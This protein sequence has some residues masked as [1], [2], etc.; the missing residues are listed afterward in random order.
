MSKKFYTK[1]YD[2]VAPPEL[3]AKKTIFIRK[4]DKHIGAIDGQEIKIEIEKQNSW[5]KGSPSNKNKRPYQRYQGH[6]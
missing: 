1:G 4:L 5:C 2:L 6:F 3:R